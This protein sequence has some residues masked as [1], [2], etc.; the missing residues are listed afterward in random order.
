MVGIRGVGPE[1]SGMNIKW[2]QGQT[3]SADEKID[4]ILRPASSRPAWIHEYISPTAI[5]AKSPKP[6]GFFY[7]LMKL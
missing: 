5:Q 7:Q 3:S 2:Q 6:D 4:V 1:S